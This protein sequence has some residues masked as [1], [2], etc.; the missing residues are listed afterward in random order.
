MDERGG[1]GQEMDERRKK[2]LCL[3]IGGVFVCM[4]VSARRER[5]E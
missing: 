5:G 2:S 3:F 4:L 1:E